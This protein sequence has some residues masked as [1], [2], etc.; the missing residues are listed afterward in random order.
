MVCQAKQ[1]KKKNQGMVSERDSAVNLLNTVPTLAFF[2]VVH[3][4]SLSQD[5]FFKVHGQEQ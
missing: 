5:M 4:R 3:C 1:G 2:L